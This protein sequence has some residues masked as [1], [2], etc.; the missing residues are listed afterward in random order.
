[1]PAI[2]AATLLIVSK[3]ACTGG[4]WSRTGIIRS[5]APQYEYTKEIVYRYF[6]IATVAALTPVFIGSSPNTAEA[7]NADRATGGVMSASIA[8]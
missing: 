4:E 2:D 8:I 3:A 6:G 5:D 7:E 1:M